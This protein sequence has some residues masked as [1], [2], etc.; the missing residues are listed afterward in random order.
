MT[1]AVTKSFVDFEKHGKRDLGGLKGLLV[2]RCGWVNPEEWTSR[3]YTMDL[4]GIA[5]FYAENP[6]AAAAVGKGRFPYDFTINFLGEIEQAH[7]LSY[8]GKHARDFS[9][10]YLSVGVLGDFNYLPP[11]NQAIRSSSELFAGLLRHKPRLD[12]LGHTDK[13]GATKDE[14][15]VCPGKFYP[16]DDV[17]D[18]ALRINETIAGTQLMQAGV[19]F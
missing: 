14:G 3:G 5:R 16:M 18:E 1:L 6:V 9:D 19:V 7:P 4:A 2:H 8:F 13:K 10:E 12:I 11:T 15:K 17:I